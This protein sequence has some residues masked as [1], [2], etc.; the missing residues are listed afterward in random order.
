MTSFL[1]KMG[2]SSATL[3]KMRASQSFLSM[4]DPA[5]SDQKLAKEVNQSVEALYE[6]CG[7]KGEDRFV[8]TS[9]EAEAILHIFHSVLT[10]DIL[11]NGKNHILVGNLEGAASLLGANRL[12]D[13]GCV[14]ELIPANSE[15][16]ITK[17][18]LNLFVSPKT[19][20][21][22]LSLAAPLI[23][24]IQPI[25]ELAEY[26]HKQ[27]IL[28]HVSVTGALGH[29]YFR[30]CDLPIDFLTF[31]GGAIGGPLMSAA[32]FI[33]SYRKNFSSLIPSASKLNPLRGG[34]FD[35][36]A[37]V[38]FGAAARNL[39]EERERFELGDLALYF[40][41]NLKSRLKEI[42]ILLAE[43]EKLPHTSIIAFPGI[44]A[45]LLLFHLHAHGISASMG[46]DQV[47][48]LEH[49]LLKCGYD[50]IIARSAIAFTFSLDMTRK[51][52]Q[53]GVETI[54]T[55]VKRLMTLSQGLLFD[56]EG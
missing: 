11:K 6:L 30:F 1:P 22:S 34:V 49:I 44:H 38:G 37:L 36:A 20:L 35:P 23:G 19:A 17:E 9:C 28:F 14:T 3:E 13:F 39:I 16:V 21:F 7:A 43:R 53:D 54:V 26:C 40:E 12:E 25:Y 8:F 31:E 51:V 5:F 27:G 47:Q 29:V 50:G 4:A 18:S 10:D 32:L 24:V 42:D 46:G 15:G 45:D 48:K 52:L 56:E 55:V 33:S 2:P 41:K